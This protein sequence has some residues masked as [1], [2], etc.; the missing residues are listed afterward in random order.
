MK[1]NK[2]YLTITIALF[3]IEVL[4]AVFFKSG[5]IR[6]T[7]GDFLVVILIYSFVK[8][9][10]KIDSLILAIAALLFAFLIEFLQLANILKLL[11]LE[12]N[13]LA[14]LILG[15]TFHL[16]DLIAYTIGIIC[17]L[18]IETRLVRFIKPNRSH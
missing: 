11:N 18:I 2:T 1:L 9:F 10:I 16:S 5:F 14:K 15:S 4:I 8:S 6:H 7:L 12:N 3:V 13:H 17:V